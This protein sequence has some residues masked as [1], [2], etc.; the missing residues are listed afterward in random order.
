MLLH[1]TKNTI[2]HGMQGLA[3][4]PLLA[5]GSKG[6]IFFWKNEQPPKQGEWRSARDELHFKAVHSGFY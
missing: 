3:A 1:F 6:V 4:R 5:S 2:E